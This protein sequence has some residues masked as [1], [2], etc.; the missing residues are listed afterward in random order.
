MAS[1]SFDLGWK[2]LFKVLFG[3]PYNLA[4]ITA[5]SA[6]CLVGFSKSAASGSISFED[7]INTKLT[8]KVAIGC[9]NLY[10]LLGRRKAAVDPAMATGVPQKMRGQ[11]QR[12]VRGTQTLV[13]TWGKWAI[14]RNQN[15]RNNIPG[16][17]HFNCSFEVL[18]LSTF[19]PRYFVHNIFIFLFI[20]DRVREN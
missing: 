8:V 6:G 2:E 10:N 3:D 16:E 9:N 18:L 15:L 19:L 12:S 14:H 1:G 7:P 5:L 13:R 17:A 11:T 4:L 20:C